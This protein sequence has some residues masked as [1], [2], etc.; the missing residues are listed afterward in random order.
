[1]AFAIAA[2]T[3]DALTVR[4]QGS[5]GSGLPEIVYER[6]GSI[7][8]EVV[9]ELANTSLDDSLPVLAWQLGLA[10]DA[11]GATGD[12]V[13]GSVSAPENSMFGSDPGP[14]ALEELPASAALVADADMSPE[15]GG[16]VIPAESSVP[17]VKLTMVP[18]SDAEGVFIFS[19][20]A[21][22]EMDIDHSSYWQDAVMFETLPFDNS[23]AASQRIEL[24]AVHIVES[25][26][27]DGDYNHDLVVDAADYTV[28]RNGLG[29]VFAEGDYDVWKENFG[30]MAGAATGT[31]TPE[32]PT[33]FLVVAAALGVV[34]RRRCSKDQ[35]QQHGGCSPASQ[36]PGDGDLC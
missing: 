11:S 17:M 22:D 26:T 19:T 23:I 30:A 34:R 20:A 5:S 32:P 4:L 15:F 35:P 2:S 3:A 10:L 33:V 28:W 27:L 21:Y 16:V 29:D 7:P 9:L 36:S 24:V 25:Q 1:V 8:L 6:G 13:I 14:L 18:S 12:L 31:P